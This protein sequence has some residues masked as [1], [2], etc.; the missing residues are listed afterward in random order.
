MKRVIIIDDEEYLR[1]QIREKLERYFSDDVIVIG[2][3]SSVENGVKIID[4]LKPDL[5]LLDIEITGGTGFDILSKIAHTGFQLIFITGFDHLAIKAIKVGAL[6]YVLKPID[7]EDFIT[8][9]KT[10]LKVDSKQNQLQELI[11]ASYIQFKGLEKKK[12]VLKT[13]NTLYSIL[14]DD[15]VYCKA[16]GNYTHVYLKDKEKIVVSKTLKKLEDLFTEVKFVRCH[17][18]FVVNKDYI[19]KYTSNGTLITTNGV[20][21]PVSSRK[22]DSLLKRIFK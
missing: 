20:K 6:D 7:D 22:K 2:E 12:I 8:A 13:A 10:T 19:E 1:I 15:I 11:E 18:S 4:S 14:E 17:N 16:D 5:L 9:I 3:A 21:I